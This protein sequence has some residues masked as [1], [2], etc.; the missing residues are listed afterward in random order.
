MSLMRE[1]F[2]EMYAELDEVDPNPIVAHYNRVQQQMEEQ[3][4]M[5]D[6]EE[7]CEDLILN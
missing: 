3:Y 1:I 5:R 6:L 2:I 4:Y 7:F